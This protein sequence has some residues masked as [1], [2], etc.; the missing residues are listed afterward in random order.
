MRATI[1]QDYSTVSQFN[2]FNMYSFPIKGL[3][4]DI[5]SG[6]FLMPMHYRLKQ[7]CE[8]LKDKDKKPNNKNIVNYFCK[9]GLVREIKC[10]LMTP[11]TWQQQQSVWRVVGIVTGFYPKFKKSFWSYTHV[12]SC[13]KYALYVNLHILLNILSKTTLNIQESR[14]SIKSL[15]R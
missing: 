11:L 4:H 9:Q 6:S 1:S 14:K 2:V 15:K 8:Y 12:N 7:V 10:L 5:P 13:Q 3:Q